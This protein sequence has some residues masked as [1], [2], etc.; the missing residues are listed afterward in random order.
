M[1]T[2]AIGTKTGTRRAAEGKQPAT[3]AARDPVL[4]SPIPPASTAENSDASVS[5]VLLDVHPDDD[6]QTT[7]PVLH[8]GVER[9]LAAQGNIAH[10][11]N[12]MQKLD[13]DILKCHRTIS[14]L[15]RK[16]A[17]ATTELAVLIRDRQNYM[18]A[19]ER[20][21]SDPSFERRQ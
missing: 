9:K 5:P 17:D 2:A 21:A 14:N 1:K 15:E 13:A 6:E 11:Q 3:P 18:Q 20:H 10:L 4:P 7:A 12:H 16:L 19:I 8:A